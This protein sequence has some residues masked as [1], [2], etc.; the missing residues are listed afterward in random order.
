MYFPTVN[1]NTAQFKKFQKNLEDG[2]QFG[3]FYD[4]FM[5]WRRA[6]YVKAYCIMLH[7]GLE[8]DLRKMWVTGAAKEQVVDSDRFLYVLLLRENMS[9]RFSPGS[10]ECTGIWTRAGHT[11]AHAVFEWEQEGYMGCQA[12]ED[13]IVQDGHQANFFPLKHFTL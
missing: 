10:L 1:T 5:D 12:K 8:Q 9:L 2:G 4:R 13:V 7:A 11:L 6:V 3:E